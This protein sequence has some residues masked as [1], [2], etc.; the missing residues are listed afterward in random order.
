MA[1]K[2]AEQ[3]HLVPCDGAAHSNAYIDNCGTCAPRWGFVCVPVSC[4]DL[5]DWRRRLNAMGRDDADY[6]RL[7]RR[8]K[9]ADTRMRKAE[10]A[11]ERA[12]WVKDDEE[13]A[14]AFAMRSTVPR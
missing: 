10:A 4:A 9:L 3:W 8:Q 6:A 1:T 14:K 5:S 12:Q 7:V 11:A 2:K 13:R